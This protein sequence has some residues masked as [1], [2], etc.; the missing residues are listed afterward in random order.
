MQ[1]AVA[2]LP[3]AERAVTHLFYFEDLAQ[4]DIA[5]FLE[6]P[7]TTVKYRLY[8]AKQQ[9]K[10][11]LQSDE[12]FA[13]MVKKLPQEDES[14]LASHVQDMLRALEKLHQ[15]F[16]SSLQ[17][18]LSE[19]LACDVQVRVNKVEQTTFVGFIELLPNPSC[20]YHYRMS[21]LQGRVIM[22]LQTELACAMAGHDSPGP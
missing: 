18:V 12:E 8:C 17:G 6:I 11:E 7:L 10:E 13:H 20:T 5:S 19:S 14:E 15:E 3:E 9:L 1:H 2:D 21:P 16:S 4:K 22:H